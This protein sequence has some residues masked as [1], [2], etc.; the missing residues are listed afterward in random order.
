M[1][2][3]AFFRP[4]PTIHTLKPQVSL[5][6]TDVQTDIQVSEETYCYSVKLKMKVFNAVIVISIELM[7]PPPLNKKL[8]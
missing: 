4:H 1:G 6:Q 7:P 3:S 8:C 5:L 2:Y